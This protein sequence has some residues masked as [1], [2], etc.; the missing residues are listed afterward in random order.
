MLTPYTKQVHEAE[1][2][3]LEGEGLEILDDRCLELKDCLE[4]Y[5]TE[6]SRWYELAQQLDQNES[7]GCFLSCGGI[8]VVDIIEPLEKKL[9]KP[10]ITTNQALTWHCL[11]KMGIQEAIGD[12]GRL[13][14][15]PLQ[16]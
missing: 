7:Q 8:Q 4:Q 9:G 10:V 5:G 2:R 12:F 11:R 6:P 14:T 15:L 3:F 13:M 1:R 16:S